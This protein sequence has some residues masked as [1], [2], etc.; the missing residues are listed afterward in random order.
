MKETKKTY[1]VEEVRDFLQQLVNEGSNKLSELSTMVSRC[2]DLPKETK[3]DI[4]DWINRERGTKGLAYFL[5]SEM[6]TE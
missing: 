5:L 1:K 3:V 4:L 6:G 2:S